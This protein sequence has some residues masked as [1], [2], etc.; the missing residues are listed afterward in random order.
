MYRAVE[1]A[2][3]KGLD[4]SRRSSFVPLLRLRAIKPVSLASIGEM[5]FEA[6]KATST[7]P[8]QTSCIF[9]GDTSSSE[10]ETRSLTDA[11]AHRRRFNASE[12]DA[13]ENLRRTCEKRVG[14]E[15][16]AQKKHACN[17]IATHPPKQ[18]HPVPPAHKS[19][20]QR[21]KTSPIAGRRLSVVPCDYS[22]T[23]PYNIL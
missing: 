10:R 2:R 21:R 13:I 3:A 11:E 4:C 8:R 9:R 14:E 16:A 15:L 18:L 6:V 17:A 20:K 19:P 7:S 5:G 23:D 12:R 22:A 1:E